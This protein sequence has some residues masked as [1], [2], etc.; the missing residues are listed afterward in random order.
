MQYKLILLF[1]SSILVS[2]CS[3]IKTNNIAPGYVE[4][5]KSIKNVIL[6][7]DGIDISSEL[8]NS[9][10]YASS[11]LKIGKGPK[12]L[13]ILEI[14]KN[15]EETWVSADG[16]ILVVRNGRII[17]T[18]GLNHN[19][20]NFISPSIEISDLDLIKNKVL[21]YYYSYDVPFLVDLEVEVT[22]SDRGFQNIELHNGVKELRL[23]EEEIRSREIN[24]RA[25]NRYWV[26]KENYIWKSIQTISPKLPEFSFEIT[27]KPS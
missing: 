10:P 4:A 9:I 11:L 18:A 16:L 17:K 21:K 1:L 20:S 22:V 15:D 27:K 23:I 25:V 8:I 14:K 7:Q 5:F 13:L 2:S 6:G 12:G 3:S 26:D 19:L 24:W